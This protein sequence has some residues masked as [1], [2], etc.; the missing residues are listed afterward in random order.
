MSVWESVIFDDRSNP[1][2]MFLWVVFNNTIAKDFV[3]TKEQI[4]YIN[5]LNDFERFF[6]RRCQS[7]IKLYYKSINKIKLKSLSAY[8][9]LILD[10]AEPILI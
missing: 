8:L 7:D 1:G 5:K 3:W 10:M 4:F 2:N 6:V 9:G